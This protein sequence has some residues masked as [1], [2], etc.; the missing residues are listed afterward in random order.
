M[1]MTAR[2]K[3]IAERL[4]PPST[5]AR[6]EEERRAAAARDAEERRL[7]RIAA[8][9][10]ALLAGDPRL[11]AFTPPRDGTATAQDTGQGTG[12]SEGIRLLGRVVER[13]TAAE[14]SARNLD[15]VTEALRGAGIDHFMVPGRSPLRYVVG[16][17][18]SDKKA[19]LTAMRELHADSAV[20]AARPG[21]QGRVTDYCA[22]ADGAL[23]DAVKSGLT[24]RFA[25]QL[26]SPRGDLF[27]GFEYGC[28]VE[29]WRDG[30]SVLKSARATD[31][32]ERLRV[33]VPADAMADALLAPRPNR[34]ADVLPATERVPATLTV[35]NREL[36][37]YRP[38]SHR[39]AEEVAF[40][41]DVVYT[42]VDGSDPVHADKRARYR[43]QRS[44]LASHAANA[45]RYTDHEELRYSLRSLQ[46]YAPFVRNIYVVTDSQV[47]YWLDA[48]EPGITVVDH[49]DIFTDPGVLPVF[50]SR[51]IE[52]QLHHIEG[53]SE[54]YLYLNDDVFFAGPVG[55]EH[56]FHANGIALLPFSSH[57]IGVG[58]PIPEEVAPNWAGKNARE[59]FLDSFGAT[60]THKVRHAPFP[61][62]REVHRELEERYREDVERTAAS[63]FRHPDDIAM[64]TTLHQYYALLSG[65]GVRGE[66]RTRYVDIGTDTAADR[67]AALAAGAEGDYDFLCLNDFDTPPE[68][69]E[70][71]SR[72]VR[73]FLERR[74]PFPSRFEKEGE[75][76]GGPD[77]EISVAA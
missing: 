51:A 73:D 68:R 43:G 13:F 10:A 50:S 48:G 40:P 24:I 33:K 62:I 18:R 54:R 16:V 64:A 32:L 14:A 58:P 66:Y 44:D 75:P 2:A 6:R 28:D 38:F 30:S 9:R 39:R 21:P 5:R 8:R 22:Y 74:F 25:E 49:R 37:T 53:L 27:A 45:S 63:R 1:S 23:S 77:P 46:M 42:W 70:A 3:R 47:P 69:Q 34:I 15:L 20:Y 19:F 67:L 57:Q 36:P 65:Y 29:F 71:V 60:I 76:V 41:V 61:Q 52:T 26:L 4:L 7:A 35:Q 55:A 56:F 72:M 59:L 31:A 11:R 12:R 17:H